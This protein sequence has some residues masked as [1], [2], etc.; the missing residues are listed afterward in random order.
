MYNDRVLMIT[1]SPDNQKALAN[2][3]FDDEKDGGEGRSYIESRHYI[4]EAESIHRK[5]Y[6]NGVNV[7]AKGRMLR[8]GTKDGFS[9]IHYPGMDG[10]FVVVDIGGAI[11]R[12]TL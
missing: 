9:G 5:L 7:Q 6:E 10:R 11:A 1:G 3:L 12:E 2:M 4:P 8:L